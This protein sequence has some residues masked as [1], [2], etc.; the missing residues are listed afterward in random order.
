[1]FH[2]VVCFFLNSGLRVRV[3]VNC[4]KDCVIFL[5]QQL[6]GSYVSQCCVFFL[7]Q[8]SNGVG[9]IYSES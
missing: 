1:M 4:L 3:R 9:S 2:S 7:K 5:T 8:R 6:V